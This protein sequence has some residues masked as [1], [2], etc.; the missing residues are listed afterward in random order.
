VGP[1]KNSTYSGKDK[2]PCPYWD[3][4]PEHK[5]CRESLKWI[6]YPGKSTTDIWHINFLNAL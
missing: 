5:A 4:N 3:W 6:C 1:K 2:T